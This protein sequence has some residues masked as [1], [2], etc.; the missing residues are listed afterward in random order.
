M[1]SKDL[2]LV[3][4]IVDCAPEALNYEFQFRHF[5]AFAQFV[6][7]ISTR[8]PIVHWLCPKL[9]PTRLVNRGSSRSSIIQAVPD[10]QLQLPKTHQSA[11]HLYDSIVYLSINLLL[12]H[13]PLGS[14]YSQAATFQL[15][16]A[17]CNVDKTA[18]ATRP[19][20]SGLGVILICDYLTVTIQKSG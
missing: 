1:L 5:R 18:P 8:N 4:T 16:P 13:I 11:G 7:P 14:L 20:S 2:G 15:N 3:Y 19:E 9:S 17:L 10:Q 12:H 6:L